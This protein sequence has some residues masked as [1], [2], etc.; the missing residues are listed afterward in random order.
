MSD[1]YIAL[2]SATTGRPA[3][4]RAQMAHS[5]AVLTAY[6]SLRAVLAEQST[7]A[8][9]NGCVEEQVTAQRTGIPTSDAKIHVLTGVVREAP[10]NSRN[11]TDV[12]WTAARQAGWS[13]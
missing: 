5:Q 6:T 7:F 11:V 1:A 8:H 12:T 13:N 9:M 4:L 2:A 10:A 3:N